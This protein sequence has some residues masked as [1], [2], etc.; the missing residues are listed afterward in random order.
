MSRVVF[1]EKTVYCRL[2]LQTQLDT[3]G[4][5]SRV[6]GDISRFKSALL[7]SCVRL[8]SEREGRSKNKFQ[9]TQTSA[10]GTIDLQGLGNQIFVLNRLTMSHH[11]FQRAPARFA[12]HVDYLHEPVDYSSQLR[13]LPFAPDRLLDRERF[14][15]AAPMSAP[16]HRFDRFQESSLESEQQRYIRSLEKQLHDMREELRQ[17]AVAFVRVMM[18][19]VERGIKDTE[20]H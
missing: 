18:N 1:V 10:K 14:F 19:Y 7:G 17:A 16:Q 15:P 20:Y 5:E 12:D 11:R 4:I 9:I 8:S 2:V 13:P 6:R 3:W